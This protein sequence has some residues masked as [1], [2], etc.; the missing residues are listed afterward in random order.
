MVFFSF[1]LSSAHRMSPRPAL[2]HV[3]RKS[4]RM[5]R[6]AA[7]RH[8]MVMAAVPGSV[9]A[10]VPA[11]V[12]ASRE[13]ALIDQARRKDAQA[14]EALMRRYNRRVYRT[15]RAIL[16]DDAEAEEAAQDAW[17]RALRNLEG[18]RGDSAF[19]T[20]LTR[21]V[22]N[23][24]LMR[25]RKRA[26][27]AEVIAIDYENGDAGMHEAASETPDPEREALNGE[28]RALLERRIDGLPELY[29]A[30]FMLRAVEELSVEETAAALELPEATV[31]T[32]YFRARAL[33]RGAL[34]HDLDRAMGDA[35]GFAGERCDRI[36]ASVLARYRSSS[37]A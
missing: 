36:V 15:A 7:L 34:E 26:R 14:I 2:F 35:F 6:P 31:R 11:S 28:L 30:V 10:S 17:L 20:W 8:P 1:G 4:N 25:R 21:I 16:G 33:M 18:F 19:A 27:R 12:G 29:R 13:Q 5:K 3:V 32:R 23:E 22:A 9:S 24:A 37:G